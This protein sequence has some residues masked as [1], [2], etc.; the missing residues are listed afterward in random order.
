MPSAQG[1]IIQQFFS[2]SNRDAFMSEYWPRKAFHEHGSVQRLPPIFSAPI[3]RDFE[4]LARVYRGPGFFFAGEG[5]VLRPLEGPALDA[6]RAGHTVYFGDVAPFVRGSRI[7]LAALEKE[8]GVTPGCARLGVFA[9]PK[10]DG[11]AVHYDT[12]D[13]F[14]VQL[15]GNKKFN[16][17]PVKELSNPTGMQYSRGTAPRPF[18][19]PQMQLGF[20]DP[21]EAEFDSID[22]SPGSVLYM[23]RGTWHFTE[24]SVDSVAVSIIVNPPPAVDAIL[25]HLKF[26]LLQESRWREPL[27]GAWREDGKVAAYQHIDNLLGELNRL[28]GSLTPAQIVES[29]S[30]LHHRL[31]L[32]DEDTRFQVIPTARLSIDTGPGDS[33][34]IRILN[35]DLIGGERETLNIRTDNVTSDLIG[36]I[37]DRKGPFSARDIGFRG[38]FSELS[39]LLRTLC[40]GQLLMPLW[41]KPMTGN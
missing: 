4:S 18:H 21:S 16:I 34:Q 17:A 8:L 28:V 38:S 35:E 6:Y 5:S 3:L 14:S 1:T 15:H 13:V 24:A 7:F 41:F 23:P 37:A 32:I 40:R 22:M 30:N 2:G 27:Y 33:C 19:Y 9:S 25:E 10:N 12:N 39:E 29:S 11:A 26:T 31:N 20:P 36:W